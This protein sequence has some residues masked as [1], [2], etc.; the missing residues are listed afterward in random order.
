MLH[1]EALRV[2]ATQ[3]TLTEKVWY[4]QASYWPAEWCRFQGLEQ[5]DPTW[6]ADPPVR[7]RARDY[8][9]RPGP[10]VQN[11][12]PK[13]PACMILAENHQAGPR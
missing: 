7:H 8:G 6:A 2:R 12:R 4:G 9:R 10:E 1:R 5:D 3:G 13:V 11:T